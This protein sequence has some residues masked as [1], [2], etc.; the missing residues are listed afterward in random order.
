MEDGLNGRWNGGINASMHQ[1][2]LS[3][4]LSAALLLFYL[5]WG[6]ILNIFYLSE[7]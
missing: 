2:S 4:S 6:K 7:I 1:Y 3:L 5:V